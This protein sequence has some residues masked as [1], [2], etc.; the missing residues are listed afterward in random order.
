MSRYEYQLKSLFVVLVL[1]LL[2]TTFIP[3]ISVAGVV[4]DLLLIWLVIMA[5][6]RGQVET[7]VAGFFIGLLQDIAA[8]K[9]LG[10]AALT[11]TIAGF[12]MGYFYNEN[13]TEGTL[14]SYRFV[15]LVFLAGFL[16]N[17]VYFFIFLQGGD[18]SIFFRAIGLS[19]AHAIYTAV[20]A[21]LPMFI[22]SRRY[23]TELFR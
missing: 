5:L 4:P 16:H 9:F 13:M 2:Q 3:M 14:G 1:L 17:L 8:T 18:D 20:I 22:F 10:L 6:K 11:K 7:T 15:M 21:V 23:S 12:A 19:V